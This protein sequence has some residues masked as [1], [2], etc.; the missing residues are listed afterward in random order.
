[1][2]R[3]MR[4]RRGVSAVE[5][6]LI[7]PLLILLYVGAA[8]IGNALTIYRRTSAV[9]STAADLTA[10]TKTVSTAD[11]QDI[12]AA[13]SSILTPYSTTPLT[14]VV[15]SV[16][17][18]ENNNGKV[19]WSYA[20]KGSARGTN[21]SYAVP[22]GLT[23]PNSSVIVAEITYA[24]TPLLDLETFFSPGSFE[25]KRIFYARPRKSLTVKKTN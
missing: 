2:V 3:L 13:S 9:A 14:I 23:Q 25:M 6:A 7:L 1:M 24:F 20:S 17:A 22:A 21:S 19:A 12:T 10:Q 15:S 5:F 18:D 16:V 11:L 4:D 8:E